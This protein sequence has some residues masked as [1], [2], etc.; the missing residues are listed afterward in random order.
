MKIK[1]LIK[2][3]KEMEMIILIMGKIERGLNET[4]K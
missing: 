3:E 2:K 4:T 1:V